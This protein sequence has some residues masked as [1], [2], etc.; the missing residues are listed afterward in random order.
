MAIF[1]DPGPIKS[2]P[3]IHTLNTSVAEREQLIKPYLPE[4]RLHTARSRSR[5]GK[6]KPIRSFLKNKLYFLVYFLIHIFFSIYL[7]FR[8]S[9][10]AVVDRV[11][12]ICYYHHRTPELIRKDVR[13]LSRLPEHLSTVLT[14]RNDE[15][16][17]EVLMDEVA[18]LVSWSSCVG[19]PMLSIYEKTGKRITHFLL[20]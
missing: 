20:V 19:I 4:P 7:R 3:R 9:Y 12:A 17:L 10:H 13:D 5:K 8:Q 11:L 18:E 6:P 1:R 14:L 16:G 15:E 2:D